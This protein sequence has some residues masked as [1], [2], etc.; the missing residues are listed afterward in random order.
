MK[1][2]MIDNR[3]SIAMLVIAAACGGES[4]PVVAP[5]PSASAMPSVSAAPSTSVAVA[6]SA[7]ASTDVPVPSASAS[8]TPPPAA[9]K[10]NITGTITSVPPAAAKN[11]LVYLEDGPKD[12]PVTATVTNSQMNFAPYIA[13][14]SVGSSVTFANADP[15]PHNVFSPDNDKF[16]IGVI[17]QHGSKA[18][19]FD[20]AG[21]YTLLCN[22]HPNMKG[23]VVSIPSSAFGK[24]DAKGAFTIKDVPA[25]TYKI[26]AWA[27]GVKPVTQSVTVA[28]DVASNFELHR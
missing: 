22:L 19:K 21:V 3:L 5:T 28:G 14:V 10:G 2:T 8:V 27:P 18:R 16:D 1:D 20:R 6:P 11:G 12:P 7:S 25:G 24:A 15:F 26:T 23:Y 4:A 13:V 17:P 9:A